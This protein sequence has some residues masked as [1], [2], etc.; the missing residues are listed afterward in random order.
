MMFLEIFLIATFATILAVG[1]S[2]LVGIFTEGY[3]EGLTDDADGS[4]G[5]V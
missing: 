2:Y 1:L 5:E 3:M 4:R